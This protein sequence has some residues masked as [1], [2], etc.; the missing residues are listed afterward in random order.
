MNGKVFKK[1]EILLNW[2]EYYAVLS[3]GYIYFY[4]MPSDE[5]YFAYYYIKDT[6]LTETIEKGENNNEIKYFT[7]VECNQ[8]KIV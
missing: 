5:E 7:M 4:L 2:E 8:R 3:G 1:N 6:K